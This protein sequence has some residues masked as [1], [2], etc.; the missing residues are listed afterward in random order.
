MA[1]TYLTGL[2]PRQHGL[3]GW[4]MYFKEADAVA[5]VLP[6]LVRQGEPSAPTMLLPRLLFQHPSFFDTIDRPSWILSP[7]SIVDS[8]FSRYH[9]G[10]AT[11]VRFTTLP[12]MFETTSSI[13]RGGLRRKYVYVYYPELDSLSHIHGVSSEKVAAHLSELDE[14]FDRFLTQVAG[15]DTLVLVC[16]DHGFIDAP[17]KRLVNLDDHPQLAKQLRQP[18]CGEQRVAY[19]Y[20][21]PGM[22]SAFEDYVRSRL[23]HCAALYRSEDLV[24]RGWFGPG[25]GHPL[26]LDRLGDFTLVMG[27]DWTIYDWL[28][29]VRRYSLLGVHGGVSADEMYVPLLMAQA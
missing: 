9:S 17:P 3:T 19:C 6:L 2:A 16:A 29:G 21:R 14:D 20:V 18:L 4:H 24:A 23:A 1:T 5:A 15:T 10:R 25:A 8:G 7:A 27:E 12:Q 26:L 13:V 11:R 22:E 28:P